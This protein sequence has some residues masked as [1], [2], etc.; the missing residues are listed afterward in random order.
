M[1]VILIPPPLFVGTCSALSVLG[2]Y[3]VCVVIDLLRIRYVERPLFKW[4]EEN[5]FRMK[6]FIGRIT[7]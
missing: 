7:R 2:V 4:V 1:L 6:D 3:T 5:D